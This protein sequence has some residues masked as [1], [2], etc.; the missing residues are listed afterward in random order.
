LKN[1]DPQSLPLRSDQAVELYYNVAITPWFRLTPDL[2]ILVPGKERTPPP[3]ARTIDTAVIVG[4][5]AKLD[6]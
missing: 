3:G 6:F 1:L 2:Q 4:L 5:R